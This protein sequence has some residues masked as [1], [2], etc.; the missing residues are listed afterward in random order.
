MRTIFD[1]F[2]F[3][4]LISPTLLIV[5]YFIG[6]I[7]IPFI[8]WKISVKIKNRLNIDNLI[9]NTNTLQFKFIAILII[10]FLF[11]EMVWRI[12]FEFLITYFQMRDALL[13]LVIK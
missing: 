5:V 10:I 4:T 1:F 6:V 11:L 9:S 13:E 3:T 7:F 2:T 8:G 12:M